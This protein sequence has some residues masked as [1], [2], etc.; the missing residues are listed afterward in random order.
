MMSMSAPTIRRQDGTFTLT[1]GADVHHGLDFATAKQAARLFATGDS[2]GA[3]EV[4]YGPEYQGCECEI[5]WSCPHHAGQATF[6]ERRY[7]GLDAE[8]ARAHG[9][10]WDL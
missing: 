7:Q 5:D 10:F 8:E 9:A 2:L 4:I 6:L 3:E 1:V